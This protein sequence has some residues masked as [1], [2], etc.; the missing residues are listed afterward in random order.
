VIVVGPPLAAAPAGE[1]EIDALLEQLLA[2]HTPSRAAAE[3]ARQLGVP[4]RLAYE[5]A[6]KLK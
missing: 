5:R 3:A 2:D 4:K 1:A 6:Q